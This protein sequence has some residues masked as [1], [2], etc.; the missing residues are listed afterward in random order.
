MNSMEFPKDPVVVVAIG[1][2]AI[3]RGQ[4]NHGLKLAIRSILG[5]SVEQALAATKRKSPYQLQALVEE[6]ARNR[7][8]DAPE[9]DRIREL[10]QKSRQATDHH[11]S[12][13]ENLWATELGASS[14]YPSVVARS[15]V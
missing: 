3:R 6:H 2:V 13:M 12:I 5:T 11:S 7:F 1:R 15:H 10:L 4:L 9:S 14:P 8:G